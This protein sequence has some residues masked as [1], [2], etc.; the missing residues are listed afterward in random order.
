MSNTDQSTQSTAPPQHQETGSNTDNTTS[1][2]AQNIDL[3]IDLEKT[4]ITMRNRITEL[5]NTL[6]AQG[7]DLRRKDFE[8][9]NLRKENEELKK[10]IPQL[11]ET[12]HKRGRTDE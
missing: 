10:R 9:E 8:L 2:K 7:W 11:H 5:E 4:I 12:G 1:L 3:Q 6:T